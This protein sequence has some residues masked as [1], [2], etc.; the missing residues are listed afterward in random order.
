[1]GDRRLLA[2]QAIVRLAYSKA[3]AGLL[4]SEFCMVCRMHSRLVHGCITWAAGTVP[5]MASSRSGSYSSC[6][7]TCCSS[8]CRRGMSS[9]SGCP[10]AEMT[11]LGWSATRAACVPIASS[12]SPTC[13]TAGRSACE[14]RRGLLGL[15]KHCAICTAIGGSPKAPTDLDKLPGAVQGTLQQH[16]SLSLS[17]PTRGVDAGC[18]AVNDASGE[19]C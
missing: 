3:A 12:P 16:S 13:A 11:T 6:C 19:A 2:A 17:G 7:S 8:A 14:Q 5:T 15:G 18:S 1:M 9:A 4:C 10:E